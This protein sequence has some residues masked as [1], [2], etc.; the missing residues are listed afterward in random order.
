MKGEKNQFIFHPSP[1]AINFVAASRGFS[2]VSRDRILPP[3]PYKGMFFRFRVFQATID[4]L[5][6]RRGDSIPETVFAINEIYNNG[7]LRPRKL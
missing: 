5:R 6:R 1:L 4:A 2:G 7:M 3:S